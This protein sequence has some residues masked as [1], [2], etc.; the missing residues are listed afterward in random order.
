MCK[1]KLQSEGLHKIDLFQDLVIIGL[2]LFFIQAY[3]RIF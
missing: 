3:I 2:F 1:A